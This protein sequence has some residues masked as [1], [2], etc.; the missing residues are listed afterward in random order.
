MA[1]GF[2]LGVWTHMHRAWQSAGKHDSERGAFRAMAGSQRARESG[3]AALPG[4]S[5]D[6]STHTAS[7]SRSRS[8]H[9]RARNI[10]HTDALTHNLAFAQHNESRQATSE[11]W[12]P[13]R[14]ANTDRLG[15]SCTLLADRDRSRVCKARTDQP[16]GASRASTHQTTGMASPQVRTTIDPTTPSLVL[17]PVHLAGG[18]GGCGAA[19]R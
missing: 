15:S 2:W 3:R 4:S 19:A 14:R 16:A 10:I 13:G 11:R 9:A 6:A 18:R 17:A 5:D 1:Q 7:A 12:W 8:H